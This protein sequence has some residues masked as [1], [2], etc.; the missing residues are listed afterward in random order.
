[1][2]WR[3]E[4][5]PSWATGVWIAELHE[6]VSDSQ[7]DYF[8]TRGRQH[9]VIGYSKAPRFSFAEARKVAATFEPTRHLATSGKESEHRENYSMGRGMVLGVKNYTNGWT[10]T[11]RDTKYFSGN[12]G[13]DGGELYDDVTTAGEAHVPNARPTLRLIRGGIGSLT[14]GGGA[15]GIR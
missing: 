8:G 13:H 3:K 14:A 10:V 11:K 4:N 2:K 7:T 15:F 9:V 12:R 5:V 1:M 6:D